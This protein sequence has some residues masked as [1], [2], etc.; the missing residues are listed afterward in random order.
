MRLRLR[1]LD[2]DNARRRAIAASYRERLAG[3]GDLQPPRADNEAEHVYHLFVVRTA[4][5]D[6]LAAGLES[7]GIGTMV[8]YPC[9]PHRQPAFAGA[10]LR[11]P[12]PV[13]ERLAGEVLSL[14]MWPAMGES[15]IDRIAEAVGQ[16]LG[17][18][19]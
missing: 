10:A 15:H 13:T 3:I 5:R 2:D 12:L 6:A 19:P 16:A 9:P 14:P 11:V 4:R 17:A 7:R 1:R 8:H 18:A